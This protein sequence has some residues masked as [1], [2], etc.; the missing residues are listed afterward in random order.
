MEK[1]LTSDRVNRH[2][3]V[4]LA[5]AKTRRLHLLLQ[6]Q[7]VLRHVIAVKIFAMEQVQSIQAFTSL[8]S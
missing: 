5:H 3:I 2:Q 6:E 8:H 4:N 1:H 7:R